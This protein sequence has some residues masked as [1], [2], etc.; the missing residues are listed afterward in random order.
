MSRKDKSR[1]KARKAR[2]LV[3]QEARARVDE[4]ERLNSTPINHSR[5]RQLFSNMSFRSNVKGGTRPFKDYVIGPH[6][7]ASTPEDLVEKTDEFYVEQSL[8]QEP[9]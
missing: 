8:E 4:Q 6:V 7:E 5:L 9:S 2:K 3:E 1:K